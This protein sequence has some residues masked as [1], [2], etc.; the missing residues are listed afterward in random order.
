MMRN[1]F[2]SKQSSYLF[3]FASQMETIYRLAIQLILIMVSFC[4]T[5][6]F[7]QE[8][9][10]IKSVKDKN[11]CLQDFGENLQLQPCDAF[12][13]K[14]RW[15]I[16]KGTGG[17]FIEDGETNAVDV[18]IES[19]EAPYL[20]IQQNQRRNLCLGLHK[21]KTSAGTPVPFQECK[22]WLGSTKM[23]NRWIR[24]KVN[25][26]PPGEA[27]GAGNLICL[28][29]NYQSQFVDKA[30]LERIESTGGSSRGAGP[31]AGYD[32]RFI[33]T[34]RF[35]TNPQELM[36]GDLVFVKIPAKTIPCQGS[37]R[38]E[39]YSN[40]QTFL[41]LFAVSQLLNYNAP[42]IAV[43]SSQ[44]PE[45]FIQVG[46][47]FKAIESSTVPNSLGQD[48]FTLM[49]LVPSDRQ[50][51]TLNTNRIVEIYA[52]A[53]N[54]KP[55]GI[56]TRFSLG[57]TRLV[58]FAPLS[59]MS[60]SQVTATCGSTNIKGTMGVGVGN[61]ISERFKAGNYCSTKDTFNLRSS[62]FVRARVVKNRSQNSA[63]RHGFALCNGEAFANAI[64]TTESLI[65]EPNTQTYR[66]P[67]TNL[68]NA[69]LQWILGDE[70]R[71]SNTK[72][73]PC[74]L[75]DSYPLPD[76]SFECRDPYGTPGCKFESLWEGTNFIWAY[77]LYDYS[78]TGGPTSPDAI[79]N[80]HYMQLL[81]GFLY[82]PQKIQPPSTPAP[83]PTPPP[84]TPIKLPSPPPEAAPQPSTKQTNLFSKGRNTELGVRQSYLRP[85]YGNLI[86]NPR[87]LGGW[88]KD[89]GAGLQ[90]HNWDVP[91]AIHWRNI[92][93]NALFH[94]HPDRN[95][96]YPDGW[97]PVINSDSEFTYR[98]STMDIVDL[99]RAQGYSADEAD[100]F[101]YELKPGH[102]QCELTVGTFSNG[103]PSKPQKYTLEQNKGPEF[104]N[105]GT[106]DYYFEGAQSASV[107]EKFLNQSRTT[108]QQRQG[109][110]FVARVECQIPGI[111][112]GNV[113]E[114]FRFFTKERSFIWQSDSPRFFLSSKDDGLENSLFKLDW[115]FSA[116]F[117]SRGRWG[118]NGGLMVPFSRQP[119]YAANPY[120]ADLNKL[121][122][123]PNN[124]CNLMNIYFAPDAQGGAEFNRLKRS[125]SMNQE[126]YSTSSK[127]ISEVLNTTELDFNVGFFFTYELN[128]GAG[129]VLRYSDGKKTDTVPRS[130]GPVWAAPNSQRA[131]NY[132]RKLRPNLDPKI[133]EG[134]WLE[135]QQFLRSKDFDNQS[136]S[137][138][139]AYC[140]VNPAFSDGL[141]YSRYGFPLDLNGILDDLAQISH[142]KCAWLDTPTASEISKV[143]PPKTLPPAETCNQ[144]L[145]PTCSTNPRFSKMR[146]GAY[147]FR[148]SATSKRPEPVNIYLKENATYVIG[149]REDQPKFSG[150]YF[151]CGDKIHFQNLAKVGTFT[152]NNQL[153][154]GSFLP[155][156]AGV[157]KVFL[158]TGTACRSEAEVP[159]AAKLCQAAFKKV[160]PPPAV[161][162]QDEI[163]GI[164]EEKQ[165]VLEKGEIIKLEKSAE[166][167]KI[168]PKLQPI[169]PPK[170]DEPLRPVAPPRMAPVPTPTPAPPEKPA[171]PPVKKEP[172]FSV[173][174]V[175]PE[176]APPE[177]PAAPPVKKEPEFSVPVVK[178]EPAP[179]EKPAAP[180][181]K[182]EP[183]FSVPVV[184]PEPAPPE[185]P[186]APPAKKESEF[187]APIAR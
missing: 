182:K 1:L 85:N 113:T 42:E 21:E 127:A 104:V 73:R 174:V 126:F 62:P 168:I 31:A 141:G 183:E 24:E 123:C 79:V 46:G 47:Q 119:P 160:D 129:D 29:H 103:K 167:V 87:G 181:V 109:M 59:R 100:K 171:A 3:E 114:N 91:A 35:C 26:P 121:T 28:G 122:L 27:R 51:D 2:L 158:C 66:V 75:Y 117:D 34:A 155:N 44:V 159:P 83:P 166:D 112:K 186:A 33:R 172:E 184:K 153:E 48:L 89:V 180:P 70:R 71:S 95:H 15:N 162:S 14:Q 65:D 50:P 80:Y 142:G 134:R 36:A 88:V 178:P 128:Y 22:D 106:V 61:D 187:S 57:K 5:Q 6:V 69:L 138:T 161:K 60:A 132:L 53:E 151:I 45:F 137:R 82:D 25:L 94:N 74:M 98:I 55:G 86:F 56:L 102:Q 39:N 40:R 147:Y 11:M 143:D 105:K 139:L 165:K 96:F 135:R 78:G 90:N 133:L 4:S 13:K 177:K 175:K 154:I 63:F 146:F 9:Y 118:A 54:H 108:L 10:L 131:K 81:G 169:A 43:S 125:L 72:V 124:K 130:F 176:P 101:V 93:Q 157:P 144:N 156:L 41:K 67:R 19:L 164:Q 17:I 116:A 179:P 99:I 92:D 38:C 52:T 173:P 58:E 18:Y 16:L 149:E 120:Q 30:S 84:L 110:E 140:Q 23:H 185:K 32:S 97:I 148:D 12:N 20:V 37:D 8:L 7:A 111:K 77:Q 163:K 152:Q 49:Q 145:A 136:I 170:V 76:G 115:Q 150:N 68:N 107:F 64:S